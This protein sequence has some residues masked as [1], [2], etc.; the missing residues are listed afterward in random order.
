MYIEKVQNTFNEIEELCSIFRYKEAYELIQENKNLALAKNNLVLKK[1]YYYLSKLQ[2]ILFDNTNE[3]VFNLV[4][5][6]HLESKEEDEF[7]NA[8]ILNMLALACFKK[9]DN[10][11]AEIYFKASI[12]RTQSI[13]N[14]SQNNI[15]ESLNL[16]YNVAKFYSSIGRYSD[17]IYYCSIALKISKIEN[18]HKYVDRLLY[19]KGY[20]LAM[21]GNLTGAEKS[22]MQAWTFSEYHNND[23]LTEIIKEAI[24]EFDLKLK[25]LFD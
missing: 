12:D 19:E 14:F 2:I 8:L 10:V 7:V 4:F 23:T 22:L 1:Y 25:Y 11:R 9:G 6:L 16:Y 15:E 18:I 3:T 21:E 5:S 13:K 24:V 20:N 17:A